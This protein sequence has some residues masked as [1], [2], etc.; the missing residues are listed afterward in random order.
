MNTNEAQLT[1]ALTQFTGTETWFRHEIYRLFTYTEGV[2]FLAE[3][4]ESNWLIDRIFGLQFESATIRKE[5]FQLWTL[6]TENSIGQ[7]SCEDGDG[8]EVF[9]LTIS[10]TDFPLKEISFYFTDSVLLLPSEY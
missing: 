7:L 8:N 6:K 3:Q 4:T 9:T 10:C 5:A 2:F 1:S